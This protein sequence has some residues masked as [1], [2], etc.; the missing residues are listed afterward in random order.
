MKAKNK[1]TIFAAALAFMAASFCL[2]QMNISSNISSV[3]AASADDSGTQKGDE[4]YDTYGGGY[5]ATEQISGV[6]YTT[7]L[8]DASNG[9]PTSDAMFLLGAS[10]GHMWIGG[11]SG[12]ICYDGSSFERLDTYDGLTSARGFFEDSSGRIWVGTNDNGVVVIDGTERVHLTYKDGLP[13]SSIRIFAEDGSGNIFIGTTSGVCYADSE[14]KL[15]S[16][17]G[18]DFS[19][20]RVLKLDTDLSGR[21][22]GQTS[23]GILFAI[24]DCEVTEV[25]TSE[26]LGMEKITT[27]MA[28]PDHAGHVYIGTESSFIY[29]GRFGDKAG[30]MKRI[31]AGPLAAV[32]WINYDCGRVWA[33]STD[34][35]G[36]LD[37]KLR[38]HVLEHIPMD[39]GI[40][41]ITS[42]YQGNLWLASSTQGVLK[43]VTNNFVDETGR[44][45]LPAEV[46]NAACLFGGALYIGTDN[47]LRIIG[48]NGKSIENDLTAYI[49]TARVRCIKEDEDGNLWLATYTNDTGLVCLS[50]D[51]S[52]EAYTTENGLPD[53]AVRCVSFSRDGS[54][55]AGTNGGLAV[56]RD[57]KV[58]RTAGASDGIT[59]T[60]FLTVA[61]EEDG[62]VLAGSDGGGLYVIGK[63]QITKLGRDDGLTSEVIMR[64]VQDEKRDVFWIITSNSI[65][66]MKAGKISPVTSFPF[67]NNYDIYFDDKD[68]AW[69]L[70]SYGVY[71]VN[72]DEMLRDAITDYSLYTVENGLPYAITSNSY[73]VKDKDGNLYMPGREGVARVNINEYYEENEL[74]LMDVRSI[75]CDEE[76]IYADEDGVF[77]I[78]PSKG[79]VQ[80]MASVM[81][82]T[83]LNPTVRMYL[84]DGP[85]DGITAQRSGLSSLEYTN[86]PY[87][88]YT[89]H[90][91]VVDKTTGEVF[92]DDTFRITKAAR[93][94]ELLIV[95]GLV[96]V[97]IALF[98]GFIVWRVMRSTVVARQY[99]EI[100]Q[101][102]E[103]AERANTAKTRFLANMS[104]EIRTPIN[105]IMGMNEMA[106][107][108]DATGVPKGYFMSIMNYTL[109]IRNASESL[110]GLINDLLDIS[111]VE[112][113]KMHLV[114]Q[115]YDTQDMLRSITSMIR[116]RSTEKQLTFDVVID[117]ILPRRMYGDSGKIK[118]IV[119]NLLTNA[120][121]YTDM[122]GFVL[123]VSMDEREGETAGLRFCVKDTGMGVKE[124]DMEKL[125]TAYERLDE[126]KNSGIQGTGLGL[127]ISRKFAEMMNGKLWCES[128]YGEGSEFILCVKQ[129]IA[130]PTPIGVFAEHDESIAKGP[131]VPQFIA[132][133]ADILVVDDNPMNLNVIKG[134]LKATKVLVTTSSSGEDAIG[135]IRDSHF[136]VVLL[137]HM[138]PGMDGIETVGRIRE[139]NKELPIYVLTANSAA[140]EEFYKS[141]GFN[142][143]LSKPVDSDILEKT[144]MR[145]LPERLMEKPTK[146]DASEELTEIPN[147][148]LWL[149]QTEDISVEEGIKNSGGVSNYIFALNL[150]LETI[151]E[152]AKVI[153]DAYES[154]NIRL[155][156]IKVHALKSSARIIG[157]NA[158]SELAKRLEDAGNRKDIGFISVN[159]GRLMSDYEAFKEKLGR[160]AQGSESTDGKESIPEEDLKEAYATLSDC[161]PQM[162]YDAVEMILEQLKAFKLPDKDAKFFHELEKCLK[163][164]DWD[165]MEALIHQ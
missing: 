52:I 84:E 119:L 118:Q 20:E 120:L 90:L 127:N 106:M 104:H 136:D 92:Q 38:F 61:E 16:V 41:M 124:E 46:S 40:E 1:K 130:D 95:R 81:D 66:I 3:A 160:L 122:G 30:Q 24:D 133:D 12:V 39:S 50:A 18:A 26:E 109:D 132:P 6:G 51:G 89:L 70:S 48:K 105:T 157:A 88:D 156:T 150:F 57:G 11:Y 14:M 101:A 7:E 60:V 28:D 25:Y 27:V 80:I 19:E 62:S 161:I 134:L 10:D 94:Q 77:Q 147:D 103:D 141:K 131:Y 47:G 85:D 145:H 32:H 91:Q 126:K 49:G 123:S 23:N 13:S 21:I 115:E 146:E 162:D 113:G 112:S 148:M 155:Y 5:A 36:Y 37:E 54:V 152:N 98:A 125:F 165:G 82:Y 87:G 153:R 117:E 71:T 163:G 45:G 99:D 151:D 102:K 63:D 158:L 111:K 79:R 74:L 55:L 107:R 164:L 100:R 4:D 75:Y 42:D 56:I 35:A 128:V 65:E 72:A 17:P 93:L 142:G 110:L 67:N 64:I 31:S 108:E 29:Y 97:C 15:H 96:L 22:Y 78:P 137:D 68:N 2:P 86:L 149:Y 121:K 73:S 143:Y 43:I 135:K 44:A 9:L 114:E 83:M 116:A 139:F 138:M 154:G 69:I 33:S 58:T 144:I 34:T 159:T 76:R 129:Q 8:Y 140:D 59:N 53:N